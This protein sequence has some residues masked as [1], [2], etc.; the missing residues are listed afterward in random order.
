MVGDAQETRKRLL[1]AATEEFAVRGIAGARVDRIAAMAGANKAM[2][3]SYFGNKEDLF[4]AVFDA[5]VGT[6]LST[7][8]ID[9]TDLPEYAGRLF[10]YYC[11]NPLINRLAT[12]ARLERGSDTFRIEAIVEANLG[13]IAAIA[14]EQD[15]GRLSRRFTAPVL[16]LLILTTAGM[17]VTAMPEYETVLG[18]K[19]GIAD[20]ARRAIIV[21]AVRLL[22]EQR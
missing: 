9:A 22:V 20:P 8:P 5:Q 11:D 19:D 2:I 3:Y 17:W 15:A 10:D 14:A 12:W 7:V 6:T 18:G 4:T 21:D 16:L 1:A 13:K